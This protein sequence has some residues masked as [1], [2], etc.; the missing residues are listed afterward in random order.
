MFIIAQIPFADFRSLLPGKRGKLQ[1]PNW[2]LDEPTG[3]I[4]GFGQVST[5]N[6]SSLGLEGERSF[7]NMNHAIRFPQQMNYHREGWPVILDIIPWFRRL[8]F[9]GMFS[10]RFEIGFLIQDFYEDMIF[11]DADDDKA[12]IDPQEVAQK[13][14]STEV[15]V[16]SPD[17]SVVSTSFRNCASALLSAYVSAT[18]SNSALAQ[19]PVSETI[20]SCVQAGRT[21]LHI[22]VS[23]GRRIE[24]SRDRRYITDDRRLL[25][26]S[27]SNS[28]GRSNVL[29]QLS[30]EYSKNET[31]R[32]RTNRVL[33]S[34]LNSL[35]FTASKLAESKDDLSASAKR[36]VLRE[37]VSAMV[38][39]LSRFKRIEDNK[40]EKELETS[41]RVYS[42]AYA[43]RIDY[44]TDQLE[45][46]ST[47]WK[48]PDT[49]EIAWSY[50][51]RLHNLV[52]TTVVEKSIE[53]ASKSGGE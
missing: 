29:V 27:T 43:G 42:A 45:E 46:L 17:T 7:A 1:S 37:A 33:F 48:K 12:E 4:R 23:S 19:Y 41:I 6:S 24:A 9:D 5:R 31:A 52:I 14:L 8:Y 28:E 10:G 44:L 51:K 18:T 35:A 21:F 36:V 25:L 32:E 16:R 50:F 11:D 53:I 15:R 39:R 30:D 49:F 26:T 13:V 38:H 3:F 22:R 2:S 34:H 20:D 40:F 47:D